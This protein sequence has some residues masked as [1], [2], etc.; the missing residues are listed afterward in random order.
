MNDGTAVGKEEFVIVRIDGS[1]LVGPI[2]EQQV[3]RIHSRKSTTTRPNAET[4][5]KSKQ[6]NDALLGG[7]C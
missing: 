1:S 6:H 5:E 4:V 7:G 3:T 2:W